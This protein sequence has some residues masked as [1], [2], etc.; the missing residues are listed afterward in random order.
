MFS[1]VH[2]KSKVFSNPQKGSVDV[3]KLPNELNCRKKRRT[4]STK[5]EK[6]LPVY[7]EG[8]L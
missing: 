7:S 4:K 1:S 3:R 5:P 6:V 8:S 2:S